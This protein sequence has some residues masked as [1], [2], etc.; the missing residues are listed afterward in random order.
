MKKQQVSHIL[1][2][3]QPQSLPLPS[4]TK[5]PLESD[6]VL[7][8]RFESALK[9][10]G[11]ATPVSPLE[12]DKNL[13]AVSYLLVEHSSEDAHPFSQG[14]KKKS[15]AKA[16]DKARHRLSIAT[17]EI[18]DNCDQAYDN[19]PYTI[20]AH[21]TATKI[22]N[23]DKLPPSSS[24]QKQ[25]ITHLANPPTDKAGRNK[26]LKAPLSAN[27]LSANPITNQPIT[28]ADL[29]KPIVNLP[30]GEQIVLTYPANKQQPLSTKKISS[31]ADPNKIIDPMAALFPPEKKPHSANKAQDKGKRQENRIEPPSLPAVLSAA[32]TTE[33]MLA[34]V[35]NEK[36]PASLLNTLFNK[37]NAV[38]NVDV[39]KNYQPP[40][41]Q[42][43]LPQIGHL[44]IKIQQEQQNI[45]IEFVAQT[46]G[47]KILLDHRQDLIDKLQRIHPDQHI[48]L[49]ILNDQQ[50]KERSK[51]QPQSSDDIEE[52]MI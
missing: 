5:L 23:N 15:T 40:I 38:I 41:I 21:T 31:V 43:N 8:K 14:I 2:D 44:Q 9:L 27:T 24:K 13:S 52:E 37:L 45:M 29:A 36:A 10:A 17:E 30:T 46:M 48:Q 22:D 12:A 3:R 33:K 39:N 34:T 28:S 49:V 20:I 25:P 32:T 18:A 35:D 42:L 6:P 4:T 51:D 1:H 26:P 7:K 11:S 19:P 50:S 47:Q 16:E